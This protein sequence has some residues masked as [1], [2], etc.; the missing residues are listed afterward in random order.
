MR[1]SSSF[2]GRENGYGDFEAGLNAAVN[3]LR[4][5]LSDSA[6]EPK[7]IETVPA[8]GYRFIG[9]LTSPT[10]GT[11]SDKTVSHYR[12][13]GAIGSGG[14]GIV[15]K[16]Q[17]LKLGRHVALKFLPDEL[18]ANHEALERFRRE[19]STASSLNHPNICTIYEVEEHQGQPFIVM[20]L[21]EGE[22]LR[23]CLASAVSSRRLREP[24][25]EIE[26][27]LGIAIQIADG[28]QAA[29]TKGVIHRDIKPTNI[30]ITA[31][32]LVKIL[33]FGLAK[34]IVAT[35]Q[36]DIETIGKASVHESSH[37]QAR[38]SNIGAIIGTAGYM[39]PEQ[40]RGEEVD[41]R[42]DL[43]SFGTILYE[44][45]TGQPAFHG[46]NATELCHAV[47]T[48]TPIAMHEL[49]PTFPSA[50][51]EVVN[52]ALHKNRRL[53]Y[54]SA[55]DLR[56]DLTQ[57]Q[58]SLGT[59]VTPPFKSPRTEIQT[60]VLVVAAPRASIV[61]HAFEVAVWVRH[62]SL[63]ERCDAQSAKSRLTTPIFV[64][65]ERT[66]DLESTVDESG[67]L[68]AA[69]VALRLHSPNFEPSPQIKK[70]SV[71]P[72]GNSPG[73]TFLIKPRLTGTLVANLELVDASDKVVASRSFFTGAVF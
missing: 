21:L 1:N 56:R 55:T 3:R 49:D 32:H 28:L 9:K 52:T 63:E 25:L 22:T 20:E 23:E 26:F 58:Q 38:L 50:L 65:Y 71:P 35:D 66:F 36:N 34:L 54:Q 62:Q 11:G 18:A 29:H 8:R 59:R 73:Y 17:D 40:A 6:T 43:F 41:A 46:T 5:H 7:Y 39:S 60:C 24:V 42:S 12:I 19:A 53:R 44:M 27:F 37:L 47:R 15:Y 69:D 10:A 30:F 2:S 13:L 16:A 64:F 48:R 57:F 14:M 61:E 31:T 70:I 45:G 4:V 33:D 68:L 72:D 51:E 67:K